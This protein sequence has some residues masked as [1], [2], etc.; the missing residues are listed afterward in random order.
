MALQQPTTA[1]APQQIGQTVYIINNHKPWCLHD[2]DH[3]HSYPNNIHHL[4]LYIINNYQPININTNYQ[5][6]YNNNYYK[7]LHDNSS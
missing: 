4:E 5:P 6:I 3:G 7:L 2:Y 1:K